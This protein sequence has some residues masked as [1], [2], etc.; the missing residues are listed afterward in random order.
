[1]SDARF[2]LRMPPPLKRELE[3][4][5]QEEGTSLNRLIVGRLSEPRGTLGVVDNTG[6][7]VARVHAAVP[8]Y[9]AAGDG[10]SS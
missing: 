7:L 3:R 10:E 1:M 9:K 2:L 4:E 6:E 5:A 8:G